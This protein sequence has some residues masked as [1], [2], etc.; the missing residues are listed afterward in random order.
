MVKT[1]KAFTFLLLYRHVF[2]SYKLVF[3]IVL[4]LVLVVNPRRSSSP[5]TLPSNRS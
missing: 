3:M 1:L 5:Y 2:H 4:S